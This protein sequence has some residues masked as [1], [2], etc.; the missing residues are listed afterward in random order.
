MTDKLTKCPACDG[1]GYFYC[2]CHPADCIC[3]VGEETCYECGGEGIIDPSYDYLDAPPSPQPNVVPCP[4]TLIEQDETC[5]VGYPS[6]LCEDCDGMGVLSPSAAAVIAI[7]DDLR[8][9]RF[10]K[11]LFD[12]RG[13]DCYI[14]DFTNGEK[15]KGLDLEVQAEIKAAWREIISK[16]Y[17]PSPQTRAAVSL[18]KEGEQ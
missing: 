17:A 7:F 6:L 1:R 3:G 8:D 15:L 2:D 14:G 18:T 9:R 12:R 5:P 4:C 13:D 10:L 11:W 16:A